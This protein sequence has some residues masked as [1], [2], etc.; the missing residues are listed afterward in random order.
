MK[1][2]FIPSVL[3]I[4]TISCWQHSS[5]TDD[6]KNVVNNFADTGEVNGSETR[7][8]TIAF[9]NTDLISPGRGAFQWIGQNRV[10]IPEEGSNKVPLDAYYRFLWNDFED[11]KKGSYDWS[12]FD[13]QINT[14]IQNGQ[15][16]AFRIMPTCVTCRTKL[17]G[18]AGIQY[19]EWLHNKMQSEAVKDWVTPLGNMWEP[20]WNS[21]NYLNAWKALN[22]ALNTHIDTSS[23]N[24]VAY[25]NVIYFIDASGWGN[26][27]EWE[28]SFVVKSNSDYPDGAQATTETLDSL[29]SYQ[30]HVYNSFWFVAF[31]GVWDGN[32]L[33]NTMV[34][35]EVGFWASSARNNAGPLGYRRDNFGALDK[36]ID[37]NW[38]INNPT[39]YNGVAFDTVIRHRYRYA[40][41]TGEPIE[42]ESTTNGCDY[43]ELEEQVRKYHATSFGNGNYAE[44]SQDCM[45][46]NVRAAS[47]ASGYR[48][49]I[50]SANIPGTIS[51]GSSF[52]LRL[53]WNN[54]GI[55]PTYENWSV[56]FELRNSLTVLQTWRSSF[57][58]TLFL[59]G[60]RIV[61]D[62]LALDAGI[63]TGSY[64]LYLIIRDPNGYRKP[65][66]L[67]NPNMQEDGSFLL[68]NISV[69]S[70]K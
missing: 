1:Y 4:V 8:D 12:A 52:T 23:Y 65:L 41:V 26:F 48:I 17:I 59:P 19:P 53:R 13:A 35:P 66:P 46:K 29:I 9:G 43:G 68:S 58:P 31:P 15:K 55:T 57:S 63:K 49:H 44:S 61:T 33:R 22:V 38:G 64:S 5:A 11:Q 47:K 16:F 40:P 51:S 50:K 24:G 32:Q 20:N 60:T 54:I 27:G 67:A 69:V 3:L 56:Q 7:Y 18:N 28:N 14:A 10:H 62:T 34:P 30:L 42:Q 39:R 2:Y 36:Y 21:T 70:K 45:R 37:N 6:E 25:K